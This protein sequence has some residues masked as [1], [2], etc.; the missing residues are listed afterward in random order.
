[1]QIQIT[2]KEF[3]PF[4]LNLIK[5]QNYLEALDRY[6]NYLAKHPEHL[7][8]LLIDLYKEQANI[9]LKKNIHEMITPN[10]QNI[11]KTMNYDEL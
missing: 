5:Q 2:N 1:M 6:K 4:N 8:T 10:T 9:K 7:A 3:L 11:T